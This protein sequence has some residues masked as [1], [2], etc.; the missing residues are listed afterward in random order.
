MTIAFVFGFILGWFTP[1]LKS[2]VVCRLHVIP[3]L[4]VVLGW[5]TGVCLDRANY[6]R[7]RIDRDASEFG[8]Q[9]QITS[10]AG[11]FCS[12]RRAD[13]ANMVVTYV[14]PARLR[15]RRL[16]V[17]PLSPS[18]CNS[19]Q[20]PHFS[21]SPPS[22]FLACRIPAYAAL[23]HLHVTGKRW[24]EAIRLSRLVKVRMDGLVAQL[25]F[26]NVDGWCA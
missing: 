26:T 17:T 11:N 3:S 20:S 6:G 10:L 5:G 21:S 25:V 14:S 9:P 4:S 15:F 24:E 16:R 7:T 13:G 19:F 8:Q 18:P 2:R 12:I 22:P 23:L 1:S